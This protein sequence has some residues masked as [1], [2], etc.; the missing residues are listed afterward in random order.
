MGRSSK[1]TRIH[2]S[3]DENASAT[4]ATTTTSR[5]APVGGIGRM[6]IPTPRKKT[7]GNTS[8]RDAKGLPPEISSTSPATAK[9]T[10]KKKKKVR[11][12][13]LFGFDDLADGGNKEYTT[14][15]T[16][17]RDKPVQ[18]MIKLG[19]H[20]TGDK[21][22]Q[23]TG[24]AFFAMNCDYGENTAYAEVVQSVLTV[25][26]QWFKDWG[27]F[28]VR[29]PTAPLATKLFDAIKQSEKLK[30]TARR[31]N[32][33]LDTTPYEHKAVTRYEF[34]LATSETQFETRADG[35]LPR[36]VMI[37]GKGT[38][39]FK[40]FV[41]AQFPT[42]RYL[43]LLF[44]GGKIVK[45]AWVLPDDDQTAETGTLAD[46]LEGLGATVKEVDLDDD[47]D[48]DDDAERDE[49]G[50]IDGEAEEGGGDE[51]EQDGEEGEGM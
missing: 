41:K 44:N 17:K 47:E 4:V 7:Q 24:R 3:D 28:G 21:K 50:F 45:S 29:C 9:S 31:M 20:Q 22:G 2:D 36:S 51:E 42:I 26:P 38:Y 23:Y 34:V 32:T 6:A 27:M 49:D 8:E 12:D 18:A 46:F 10:E 13:E 43:D 40:D 37:I 5:K 1:R 16:P 19:T 33:D 39:D 11:I 14:T 30:V 25:R 48:E 15:S 35:V